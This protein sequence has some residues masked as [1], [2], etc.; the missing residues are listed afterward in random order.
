[1]DPYKNCKHLII[2]YLFSYDGNKLKAKL[3]KM[4]V[5]AGD[6]L[7]VHASW[8]PTSG[9][10]GSPL[11]MIEA[12]KS[13]VGEE[14]LLA[15]PSMTY[16]N[17]SSREFLESG[18][19]VDIRRS[20]SKMGILSEVFRRNRAVQRSQSVT[21]PILVWGK[22]GTALIEG[23]AQNDKPFGKDS[24]FNRLLKLNGKVLCINTPFSSITFTHHLE[25]RIAGHLPFSLYESQ[26]MTGILIDQAGNRRELKAFVL[27]ERANA[28]RCEERLIQELDRHGIIQRSRIGNT[29]LLLVEC[30]R[31]RDCVEEMYQKGKSFFDTPEENPEENKSVKPVMDM[32][33]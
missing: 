6:A 28:L 9:F 29:R 30:Q 4:G 18:K 1:M 20:P 21:H 27:S 17:Q 12:L 13:T 15:M 5:G 8:I 19:P 7:M 23:Q 2:K 32:N 31:M 33:A 11:E 25:D 24:V 3:T 22:G 16:H 26:P 14:G 10:R